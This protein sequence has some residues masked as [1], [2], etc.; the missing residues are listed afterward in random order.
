M[1]SIYS[2]ASLCISADCAKDSNQGLFYRRPFSSYIT[3]PLSSGPS[4]TRSYLA[5]QIDMGYSLGRF[6]QSP[7]ATRA[8]TLQERYLSL[9]VLHL[10][11][12]ELALE[13][14]TY[15]FNEH[16]YGIGNTLLGGYPSVSLIYL[17]LQPQAG[18]C[19]WKVPVV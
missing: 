19:Y 16:G 9:R 14:R 2:S 5:L 15:C 7:L 13:C 3:L 10:G 18:E 11:W 4:S 17:T 12:S 8:W 1:H 6:L